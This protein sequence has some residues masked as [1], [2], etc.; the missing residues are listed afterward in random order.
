MIEQQIQ[1]AKRSYE[2]METDVDRLM[3][4]VRH[5]VASEE[6]TTGMLHRNRSQRIVRRLSLTAVGTFTACAVI[7]GSGLVSPVMASVLQEIP[8]V[9]SVFQY[10]RDIGLKTASEKGMT[11]QV[12]QSVTDNGI[13]LQ[14]QEVMYDGDRLSIGYIQQTEDGFSVLSGP[15]NGI[16]FKID[17]KPYADSL[18]A[19]GPQAID[20]K[21]GIGQI[22]LQPFKQKLPD[23]FEL[24]IEVAAV[25]GVKGH[26]DFSIPVKKTVS[27]MK[28]WMPMM[29]ATDG[30]TTLLIKKIG[31]KPGTGTMD[32]ELEYRRPAAKAQD[33][34]YGIQAITDT[35]IELKYYEMVGD[36]Y[37]KD[38]T[39]IQL[40]TFQ[41][42]VP[43]VTTKSITLRPYLRGDVPVYGIRVPMKHEPSTDH[44]LIIPQGE[45][46][47]LLV[48]KVERLKDKTMVHY[49]KEVND[50]LHQTELIIEDLEG[51]YNFSTWD[52]HIIPWEET[53][54][55]LLDAKNNAY[56]TEFPALNPDQQPV[57]V[58][59]EYKKTIF[60]KELEMTFPIQ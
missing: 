9:G 15:T 58:T 2:S 28:S 3:A 38:D 22:S 29:S 54:T 60:P 20:S 50:P 45:L 47:R 4:R 44:P 39:H 12:Q 43:L 46:G 18:G 14:I 27:G 37:I 7:L 51:K 34:M 8:F 31:F 26:W 48:T 41:F 59:H 56:V 53:E 10:V 55:R 30:E 21:T 5:S 25:G 13:T 52:M 32:V 24:T 16:K 57:F 40:G 1:N 11:A 36:G 33:P 19:S 49:R 23:E 35:G 6:R 17:G 42:E